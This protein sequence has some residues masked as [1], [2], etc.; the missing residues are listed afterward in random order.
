MTANRLADC[1]DHMLEATHL[2]CSYIEGM[3]KEEF[4]AGKRTQ[5]AVIMNLLI[6]GEAPTKL[7][8]DHI[9]FLD[10]HPDVPWKNMKGMRN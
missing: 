2:A 3:S 10:A 7:L 9:D 6:I 5:Q 8:K 4:F 1:L